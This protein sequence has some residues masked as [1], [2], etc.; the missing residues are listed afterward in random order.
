MR[1]RGESVCAVT[2]GAGSRWVVVALVGA[3]IGAGCYDDHG[4]HGDGGGVPYDAAACPPVAG[5]LRCGDGCGGF[6]CRDP[7]TA[8]ACRNDLGICDSLDVLGPGRD[9]PRSW[10]ICR[11]ESP[12]REPVADYCWSGGVCAG[13]R[14]YRTDIGWSGYC[15]SEAFCDEADYL[16]GLTCVWSDRSVRRTGAPAVTECPAELDTRARLCGGPCGDC[17]WPDPFPAMGFREQ[18]YTIACVGR[19]DRRGV[20]VCAANTIALCSREGRTADEACQ[21]VNAF[22][23]DPALSVYGGE[24]CACLA[25]EDPRAPGTFFEWGWAILAESCL[26]YRALYPDQVRCLGNDWVDL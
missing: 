15:V 24:P 22:H 3:L 26:E 14:A 19:S 23:D 17:P 10:D 16:D 1:E 13:V 11:I 18:S 25:L 6:W 21:N 5:Y 20:G 7:E 12:G 8:T 2:L 9:D 4:L